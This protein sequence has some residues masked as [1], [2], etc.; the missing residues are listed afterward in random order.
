ME[1]PEVNAY[2]EAVCAQVRC[3]EVHSEVRLELAGHIEDLVAAHV[4]SG[5]LPGEAVGRA[6]AHMGDPVR[7][8]RQ[9]HLAHRPHTDWRLLAATQALVLLGIWA[10]YAIDASGSFTAGAPGPLLADQ[11]LGSA[12]GLAAAGALFVADYRRLRRLAWPLYGLV[13]LGLLGAAWAEPALPLLAALVRSSPLL[14]VPALA[15]ILSGWDWHAPGASVRLPGLLGA[16]VGIYL[17]TANLYTAAEFMAVTGVLVLVARPPRRQLAMLAALAGGLGAGVALWM[18]SRPYHVQRLLAW[19]NPDRDPLDGGYQLVQAR[20]AMQAAGL[21]GHGAAVPLDTLP[22]M[23]V[24]FVFPYLVHTLG[25]AAGAAVALLAL[26]F[27]GRLLRMALHIRDRYGAA[28]VTGIA[29]LF[30]VRFGW[31]LLMTLGLA[32]GVGV[33]LPF[34][35][36]GWPQ[37]LHIALAGLALGVFRRKDLGGAAVPSA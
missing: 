36:H 9:L 31:N 12:V 29:A 33:P 2:L 18:F 24:E 35:S 28:L 13:L 19:I 15:G 14:L 16:P 32:P 27:V 5:L 26:F 20:Q 37:V 23:P 34:V 3:K 21:W 7:V 4:Q 22:N 25:W 30:A 8:G 1:Y 6:L 10:M 17:Y 11:L